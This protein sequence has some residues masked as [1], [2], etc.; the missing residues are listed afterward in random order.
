MKQITNEQQLIFRP[1]AD[2]LIR[3]RRAQE[4]TDQEVVKVFSHTLEGRQTGSE[5]RLYHK[6]GNMVADA[7]AKQANRMLCPDMV[8][9]WEIEYEETLAQQS[10]RRAHYNVLLD[11]QPVRSALEHNYRASRSQMMMLPVQDNPTVPLAVLL[12]QWN[13]EPSFSF[14]L[15]WPMGV[16]LRS[17]WGEEIML[18]MIQWQW[19]NA[20]QW[21][22]HNVGDINRSG[23]SWAE[24]VLDFLQ[25]RQICIPTRHPYSEDKTLQTDM[26]L[27]KRAGVGF[28]HVIKKFYYAMSWLNRKLGWAGLSQPPKRKG[29]QPSQWAIS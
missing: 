14:E 27:L 21:P 28:Y 19:W 1:N 29:D 26:L 17:P 8:H 10:M 18:E 15:F 7:A 12:E 23:V 16:S 20:L 11:I 22:V 9:Q 25:D 24:L 4:H 2:L 3:L 5:Q 6:L 13:P